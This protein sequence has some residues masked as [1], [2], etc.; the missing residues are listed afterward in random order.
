[1]PPTSTPA[2]VDHAAAGKKV[3]AANDSDRTPA[4]AATHLSQSRVD[5]SQDID[6]A[7]VAEIR[8]AIAE[9]RLVVD[10]D[11]IADRLLSSAR[12]LLGPEA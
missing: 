1:M 2:R 8:Q 12:D 6:H 5:G 3:D 11:R 4:G 7:R 9:G 10:T